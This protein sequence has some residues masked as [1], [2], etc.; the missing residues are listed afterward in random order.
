[1]QGEMGE[2]KRG[3]AG[4]SV[5]AGWAARKDTFGRSWVQGLEMQV[6]T[7]HVVTRNPV[8]SGRLKEGVLIPV[9]KPF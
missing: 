2:P 5:P 3:D 9:P 1:M 7:V 4:G 6:H 8:V